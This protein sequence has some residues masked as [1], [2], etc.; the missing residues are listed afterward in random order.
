MESGKV[1][2]LIASSDSLPTPVGG[3]KGACKAG[4]N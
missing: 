2:L 1:V 4:W 3:R